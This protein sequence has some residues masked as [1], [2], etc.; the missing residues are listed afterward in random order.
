MRNNSPLGVLRPARCHR[1]GWNLSPRK[2]FRVPYSHG[3]GE[4]V[5][6][7]SPVG[8]LCGHLLLPLKILGALP[9]DIC[10]QR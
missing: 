1:P 6:E 7:P 8:P 5:P 2:E 3:A 10:K 9:S 4:E